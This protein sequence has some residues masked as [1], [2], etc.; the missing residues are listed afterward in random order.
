MVRYSPIP[1]I[2]FK[3]SVDKEVGSR[4]DK[5]GAFVSSDIYRQS[6]VKIPPIKKTSSNN[7]ILVT[8]KKTTEINRHFTPSYSLGTTRLLFIRLTELEPSIYTNPAIQVYHY[9]DK[10]F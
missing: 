8:S 3:G 10:V 7:S 4:A 9:W 2:P 1:L 6:L 5:T